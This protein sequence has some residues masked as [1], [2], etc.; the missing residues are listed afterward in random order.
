MVPR[1]MMRPPKPSQ[2][3]RWRQRRHE[4]FE[5]SQ[6]S[7]QPALPVVASRGPRRRC[8]GP[9]RLFRFR[10]HDG[11]GSTEDA[12]RRPASRI[13]VAQ[14]NDADDY[15]A[16]MAAAY[17]EETGVEIEV[18]PYPSDAYNTQVTTQLQAGNAADMMILVAGNRPGDLGHH[19]RRGGLPRAARRDLGRRHPRGHG[20]RSTRS[21]A[22]S[23]ASPRRSRPSAWSTTAPAAKRWASRTTPRRST[24]CSRRAPPRATAARP[25]RS[26]PAPSRST[27]ACSR[28]LIS[29]TRVYAGRPRL[30]R[31][32]RSRRRDLRRQ[33][34]GRGPRTTSSR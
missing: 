14:A 5:M 19:P 20:E 24:T 32:A 15:Y 12:G 23:T 29:A 6:H 34:L 13:M 11:G 28:M 27:R 10:R 9:R 16:Q 7:P 25:S 21:T 17:T 33:R 2:L 22:R 1:W 8:P 31:A 4:R 26:S 30:E 18:I 3:H